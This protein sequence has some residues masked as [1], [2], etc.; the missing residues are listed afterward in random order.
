[1]LLFVIG[2]YG[3]IAI[4]IGLINAVLQC[5]NQKLALCYDNFGELLMFDFIYVWDVKRVEQNFTSTTQKLHIV[6]IK[7]WIRL[8]MFL[9]YV[10]HGLIIPFTACEQI[11]VI[12]QAYVRSNAINWQRIVD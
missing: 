2:C 8:F 10:V 12:I 7:W 3:F 11:R 1:M 4:T 6:E 5:S 9:Y